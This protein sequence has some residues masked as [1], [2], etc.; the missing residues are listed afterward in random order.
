M[1]KT[2]LKAI[3]D[4]RDEAQSDMAKY[5]STG[6]KMYVA[7]FLDDVFPDATIDQRLALHALINFWEANQTIIVTGIALGHFT[8]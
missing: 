8:K 5:R 4:A 3:K 6:A 1:D 7:D 2:I